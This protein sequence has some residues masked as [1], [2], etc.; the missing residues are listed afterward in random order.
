MEINKIMAKRNKVE[1]QEDK[2]E[3]K[4]FHTIS[5]GQAEKKSVS[6]SDL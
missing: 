5:G 1:I 6:S 4:D 3:L 2:E